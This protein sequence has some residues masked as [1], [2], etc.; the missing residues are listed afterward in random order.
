MCFCLYY[1]GGVS[2]TTT[3]AG[4]PTPNK[5]LCDK[6][7][8]QLTWSLKLT[9][10]FP[11]QRVDTRLRRSP[12]GTR[13]RASPASRRSHVPPRIWKL[14]EPRPKFHHFPRQIGHATCHSGGLNVPPAILEA[15][16][17]SAGCKSSYPLTLND[18]PTPFPQRRLCRRTRPSSEHGRGSGTS[19]E[20]G[21]RGEQ[22]VFSQPRIGTS[23]G[24]RY[25]QAVEPIPCAHS[26]HRDSTVYAYRWQSIPGMHNNAPYAQ[27]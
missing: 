16:D 21:Y 23:G 14:G 26:R 17:D 27:Q 2:L 18:P 6:E 9:F 25:S 11:Q 3:E 24:F 1:A 20:T 22:R 5:T 8:S 4:E 15:P 19:S 12:R 10:S 13:P 7:S